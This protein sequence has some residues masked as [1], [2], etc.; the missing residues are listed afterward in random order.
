ME[1]QYRLKIAVKVKNDKM[2]AHSLA[3]LRLVFGIVSCFPILST[4]LLKGKQRVES[5]KT[6]Q[7]EMNCILQA[8]EQMDWTNSSGWR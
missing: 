3:F 2:S 6:V 7:A 8:N 4:N 1:P 5:I